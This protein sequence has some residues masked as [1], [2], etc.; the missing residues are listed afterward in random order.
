MQIKYSSKC[1]DNVL[2][3]TNKCDGLKLGDVVTFTAEIV[4]TSCPTDSDDWHQSFNIYAVGINE[5]LTVDLHML[6]GCPCE[7]PGNKD[8]E[9]ASPTCNG[10]GAFECGLCQCDDYH[11]GR[12]CECNS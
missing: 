2:K 4:V 6:C 3:S 8:Y 12:N 9:L 1:I 7:N 11:Y 10:N 5:S